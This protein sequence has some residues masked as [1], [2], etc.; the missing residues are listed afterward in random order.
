MKQ[1]K[2]SCTALQSSVYFAP[3]ELRH[4][5]KRFFYKGKLKGDVKIFDIKKNEKINASEILQ[6][7]KDL[8]NE[9]NNN[10]KENPC[11][12]CPHLV[13]DDWGDLEELKIKH[14][15]IEAHSVC[16]MKCTYCSETYFG[17]KKANYDLMD[18]LNKLIKEK[19]I[20]KDVEIAWG[21][22]EPVLL[23]NFDK[24]FTTVTEKIKPFGNMV[25]SN[26]I[27]Y[28]DNIEKFLCEDKAKLTTSIDAGNLE[29][30][31]KIRGVMAFEKVLKNLSKYY[32][33]AKKNIII[34]YILTNENSD[35][36]NLEGFVNKIKQYDL[37]KCEF[38]ISSNFKEEFVSQEHF[39]NAVNLYFEL[40]KLSDNNCFF[41]YH[42]KPKIQSM[43]KK[44][45]I[46]K[47]EKI[48]KLINSLESIKNLE[49]TQIVV[50]GAG[51]T[52][53]ELINKSFFLKYKK[54]KIDFF[55]DKFKYNS[56]MNNGLEI[57][58]PES[59]LENNRPILIASTAYNKEIYD[60][61]ISMG[62]NK[63]RIIDN[64]F[65]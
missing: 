18:T 12:G 21:G 63:N 42:L 14:I 52:G 61:I 43:L 46:N 31:K 20:A 24:I 51:D 11:T 9:I 22:G 39:F 3:D 17:G 58:S 47:D 54:V 44:S 60:S 64:L 8:I 50:W 36:L 6:G 26:A 16:Q 33:S 56:F 28:N 23:E 34:K 53:R 59:L 41:D 29:T 13:K 7:K 30:F 27:K 19:F 45:L 48:I 65:L 5:C 32:K 35:L 49:N 38:Q 10:T 40:K 25:Y 15:S 37:I 1:K 2:Y 57:K 55:V 62:I 4:C